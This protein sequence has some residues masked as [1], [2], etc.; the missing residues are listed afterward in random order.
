MIES[1][2]HRMK[3]LLHL[4]ATVSCADCR[5]LH[6]TPEAPLPYFCPALNFRGKFAPDILLFGDAGTTCR[7]FA[8]KNHETTESH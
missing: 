6:V 7:F 8:S 3:S 2:D 1:G 5:H 4:Q